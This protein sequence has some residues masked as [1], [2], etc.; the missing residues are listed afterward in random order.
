MI[1]NESVDRLFSL[2]K[3][4]QE[5]EYNSLKTRK[6]LESFLNDLLG[7]ASKKDGSSLFRSLHKPSFKGCYIGYSPF[8]RVF[9]GLRD[10]GFIEVKLGFYSRRE[11]GGDGTAARMKGTRALFEFLLGYGITPSNYGDHFR[12]ITGSPDQVRDPVRLRASKKSDFWH[13]LRG[14]RLPIDMAD[15]RVESLVYQMQGL[16]G[17]VARH[18]FTGCVFEGFFRQFN[19]GRYDKGGRVYAIGNFQN[20]EREKRP[21]IRINGERVCEVDV[22]ASHLTI[23]YHLLGIPLP[24]VDDLYAGSGIDNRNVVKRFV[25]ATLGAGKIPRQWPKG[26]KIDYLKREFGIRKKDWDY[27]TEELSRLQRDYPF[28]MVKAA[29]VKALPILLKWQDSGFTWADLQY[30]ESLGLIATLEE[31]AFR[32]GIPALPL[33]D[34]VIVPASKAALVGR[35]MIQ[36]FCEHAGVLVRVKTK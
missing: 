24:D 10:A 32:H 2:L 4:N 29:V 30:R 14:R 6:A 1:A 3:Q 28:A 19:Q 13:P 25:T 34:S 20:M 12:F 15:P 8:I 21:G 16:N 23:A 17:F 9:K 35:V 26:S 18:V 11:D 33:H 27:T 31:L 22:S 36:A 5:W 7:L